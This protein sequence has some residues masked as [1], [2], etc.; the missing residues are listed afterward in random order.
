MAMLDQTTIDQYLKDIDSYLQVDATYRKRVLA[1]IEGHL[2]DAVEVQVNDGVEPHEAM[3]R[4]I[5]ELGPPSDVAM[6]FAPAPVPVR[7]IRGWRRWTPIVLPAA[8]LVVALMVSLSSLLLL[9]HGLT[10]GVRV[11]LWH[12]LRHTAVIGALAAM[13]YVA[14]GNGDRDPAWRR[15]AWVLAAVTAVIVALSAAL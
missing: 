14:I 5:A 12:N 6:Q 3:Q 4:A 10:Y 8:V 13:T 2:H 15:A 11:V 7:S 1:E 9:R